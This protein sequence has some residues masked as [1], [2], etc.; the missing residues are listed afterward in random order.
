[1]DTR[2]PLEQQRPG[3]STH[4]AATPEALIEFM[5]TGWVDEPLR[6]SSI[7]N[8]G[9]F[10]ERRAQLSR[11]FRGETL[12]IPAGVERVRANDTNFRFRPSSDF[13]YLAGG[14][15]EPDSLLILEPR[16]ERHFGWDAWFQP[17]GSAKTFA[18]MTSAEKDEVSHRGRAYR[19]LASHLARENGRLAGR[20]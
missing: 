10:Q 17:S 13:A 7:P 16:G 12:V 4:D 20:K 2:K 8:S 1:M 6:V 9:A 11:A 3:T 5:S 18:E 19:Q 15:A 14:A